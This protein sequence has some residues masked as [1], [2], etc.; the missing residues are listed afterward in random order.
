MFIWVLV[1]SCGLWVVGCGCYDVSGD[2]QCE[3]SL[4]GECYGEERCEASYV[5]QRTELKGNHGAVGCRF[6]R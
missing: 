6:P 1:I 3:C 2:G 4:V 5:F